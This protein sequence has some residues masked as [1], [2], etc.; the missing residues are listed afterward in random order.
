MNKNKALAR[1]RM[2]WA[3]LAKEGCHKPVGCR[4]VFGHTNFTNLCPICDAVHAECNQCI[5]WSGRVLSYCEAGG[6]PYSMW[7][8][9]SSTTDRSRADR[10]MLATEVVKVIDK[11]IKLYDETGDWR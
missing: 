9:G 11:A 4:A 3:Y 7:R 10:R 5:D 8:M 2:L 1:T 6:S